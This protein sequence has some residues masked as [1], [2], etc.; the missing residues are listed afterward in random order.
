MRLIVYLEDLGQIQEGNSPKSYVPAT[1]TAARLNM[2]GENSNPNAKQS[3]DSAEYK[4]VL[5]LEMWKRH[6]Q[7]KFKSHLKQIELEAIEKVTKYWQ[8]KEAE[9]E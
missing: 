2:G 7:A 4:I 6:E 9:R 3:T 5:E 8:M 1:V